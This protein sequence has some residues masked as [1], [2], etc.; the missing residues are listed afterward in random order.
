MAGPAE[1][2]HHLLPIYL[3]TGEQLPGK[4]V[5]Q[6]LDVGTA[7]IADIRMRNKDFQNSLTQPDIPDAAI[8][9]HFRQLRH[10]GQTN[11]ERTEARK[12]RLSLVISLRLTCRDVFH[13]YM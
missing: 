7:K 4:P 12:S 10:G 8:L 5:L 9:F 13:R 1:T 6:G 2:K 11:T 3:R